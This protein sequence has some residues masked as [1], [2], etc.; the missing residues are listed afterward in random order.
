MK[1][2]PSISLTTQLAALAEPLRLRIMRL[3]E[4]SELS[5][6]EVGKAIQLP[7]STVSRHL[8]VLS[9]AGWTAR[10]P[11]GTATLYRLVLDDL[12]PAR[13]DL[14]V[15]V[16]E[17]LGSDAAAPE[18]AEDDRR[19]RSVLNERRLDS[20][21]FFGRVAGQWDDV[22]NDLFGADFTPTA[23]L[24]LLDPTWTIADL[25][26]GTGNAAE[27]LA[28]VVKRVIVVDQSSPMLDAAK[29]RLESHTNVEFR[30]GNIESLPI[31]DGVVDAAVC[32]LVLHHLEEPAAACREARRIVRSGGSALFV[33]MLRHD[34]EAYRH[35]MGHRWLGF[36][37]DEVLSMLI[38]A[39]FRDVRYDLLP[40]ATESRGPGLF[41]AVGRA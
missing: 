3:L 19:L 28:P 30:R 38:A 12:G 21:S 41:V 22:R 2:S 15:S 24:N 37:R 5:V 34:R 1:Q 39:G 13:R 26:C 25:G 6:G 11:D 18:L 20:K 14:W 10:R 27:M 40:T 31:D 4:K 8:R 32:L 33:D 17:G 23:L 7:Q 29:K 36:G 16:R 35:T 9:E